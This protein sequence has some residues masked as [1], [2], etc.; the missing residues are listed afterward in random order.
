MKI[1]LSA[2]LNEALKKAGNEYTALKES[3]NNEAAKNI[4]MIK[5]ELKLK[6]GELLLTFS[7]TKKLGIEE[8][9]SV[10]EGVLDL[11]GEDVEEEE[12]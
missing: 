6:K 1:D 11:D 4:S 2:P 8:L 3:G 7:A 9:W 10:L 12:E 5:K